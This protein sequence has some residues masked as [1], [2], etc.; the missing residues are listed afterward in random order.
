VCYVCYEMPRTIPHREL[1]NNSSAILEEVRNGETFEVTNR[2]EPV[3]ILS[4]PDRSPIDRLR[5]QPATRRGEF[6]RIEGV[7][8]EVSSTELLRD[9]RGER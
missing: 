8:I 2:G 5:V 9:L 7:P 3:A 6:S 4:P 1:R